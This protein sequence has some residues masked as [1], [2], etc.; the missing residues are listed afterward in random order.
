MNSRQ[1][2]RAAFAL[3]AASAARSAPRRRRPAQGRA[4]RRPLSAAP[5]GLLLPRLAL[6]LLFGL[7]VQVAALMKGRQGSIAEREAPSQTFDLRFESGLSNL[8]DAL[9]INGTTVAPTLKYDG[10][11]ATASAWPALA[12][13]DMAI[14]G[15]GSEPT[16]DLDTPLLDAAAGSKGNAGKCYQA[17]TNSVGDVTTQDVVLEYVGTFGDKSPSAIGRLMA[18]RSLGA[19]WVLYLNT[20]GPGFACFLSDG[21]NT[22][23]ILSA[24]TMTAGAWYHVMVFIDRSGSAQI[25]VNGVASGTPLSVSSVNSITADVPLTIHCESDAST[26]AG[27]STIARLAMWQ[28]AGW[29]DTHLQPTIAKERF[30]S[31]CGVQATRAAGSA[32]PTTCSRTTAAYLDKT[33]AAG[34]RTAHYVGPNW[35]RIV[36]RQSASSEALSGYLPEPTVTNT[37]GDWDFTS[38]T[39][40]NFGGNLTIAQ[41]AT[42]ND[43]LGELAYEMTEGPGSNRWEVYDNTG[44]AAA[45]QYSLSVF[46]KAQNGGAW[47]HIHHQQGYSQWFNVATG[48]L[49][50]TVGTGA[51]GYIEDWGGGWYRCILSCLMVGATTTNWWVQQCTADSQAITTPHVGRQELVMLLSAPQAEVGYYA[52]SP[53]PTS[54]GTATR[55]K[56]LL[57]YNSTG[58]YPGLRGRIVTHVLGENRNHPGAICWLEISDGTATERLMLLQNSTSDQPSFYL[59]TSGGDAGLVTPGAGSDVWV[60]E[61]S[62]L[63][64]SWGDSTTSFTVDQPNPLTA[65]DSAADA[66]GEADMTTIRI[67][68]YAPLTDTYQPSGVVGPLAIYRRPRGLP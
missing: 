2:R 67:G 35:P 39:W 48:A 36:S 37:C 7:V 38:A 55:T 12:G 9:T 42:E 66:P 54:G 52:T 40:T 41:S 57:Q 8:E 13:Q 68:S 33:T 26:A 64:I 46:A 27:D 58:N 16:T 65:T 49:G 53:I 30:Y 59:N 45:T 5:W 56:D 50:S 28:S 4:P 25:Y 18:H 29:L 22:A 3:V 14:A 32:T 20:S 15:S 31:L 17:S 44:W 24:S 60:G 62:V 11:D 19:G 21:T 61:V 63:D 6:A 43:P 47:L 51:V 23:N 1:Q 10:A 34:V